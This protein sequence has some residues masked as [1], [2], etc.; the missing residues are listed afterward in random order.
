MVGCHDWSV[1]AISMRPALFP[2]QRSYCKKRPNLASIKIRA[3]ENSSVNK[4][5]RLT[6]IDEECFFKLYST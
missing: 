1:L 5:L 2:G 4:Q 3:N 6:K